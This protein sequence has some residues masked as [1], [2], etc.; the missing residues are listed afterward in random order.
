[1]K[2][3]LSITLLVSFSS[4]SFSSSFKEQDVFDLYQKSKRDGHISRSEAEQIIHAAKNPYAPTRSHAGGKFLEALSWYNDITIGN[5]NGR[6][7]LS[8]LRVAFDA[9]LEKYL[10][11]LFKEYPTTSRMSDWKMLQ[12]LKILKKVIVR[13]GKSYYPYRAKEL[14]EISKADEWNRR[15]TIRSRED[16]ERRVL[17]ASY[18]KPVLVKFG[19]TYCVHCL[20]MENLGS[21][22]A[23]SRKYGSKLSVYKL[24]WNP[25]DPRNFDE[26]NQIANEEGI[27]SSPMFN[28]YINGRLVKSGYAFP[29][30]DGSGLEDFLKNYI[31]I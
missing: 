24:W 4:Y 23:V 25:K 17:R 13:S 15:N 29:D 12:K 1:M 7:T 5:Q 2:Y 28:L 18:R 6:F 10:T 8:E 30:E 31:S 9:Q 3:F 14:S 21:V 26:L 19:L 27:T 20:L 16:F 11:A 22:P